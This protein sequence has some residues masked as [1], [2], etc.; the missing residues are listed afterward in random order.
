LAQTHPSTLVGPADVRIGVLLSI[1]AV[2]VLSIWN[3]ATL[4]EG[5]NLKYILYTLPPLIWAIFV[6]AL[7]GRINIERRSV[8]ALG[9]YLFV[10]AISVLNSDHVDW[11][12]LR[13]L[14]II[15]SY[16]AVFAL[17]FRSP[18]FVADA[19]LGFCLIA[20]VTVLLVRGI[21]SD[22]SITHPQGHQLLESV[23]SFPAGL[24]VLYYV[25]Q[26]QWGRGLITLVLFVLAFKRIAFVGVG[27]VLCLEICMYIFQR[28]RPVGRIATTA[29]VAM[30]SIVA[31]FSL[32][33]F[34]FL[35]ILLDE[36]DASANSV[37]LGR[38]DMAAE[39]WRQIYAADISQV[40]MGFGP[41]AADRHLFVAGFELNPHNDWLKIL[42]E[43]GIVGFVGLHVVLRLLLPNTS[44]GN[45][46]YLFTAIL[47]TTGNPL[48]Y[49]YY[50]VALFLIVRIPPQRASASPGSPDKAVVARIP[51]A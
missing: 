12:T 38:A 13:D 5:S 3:A 50:F 28:R 44:L 20:T 31:L 2:A 51:I 33:I 29:A 48:I 6:I 14:S 45:N 36:T 4:F 1:V 49:T 37:S 42:F 35:A 40:L 30:I 41:G 26:R 19:L 15:G 47:M 27:A 7:R 24:L 32:Q 34:E 11:Y 17:F 21:S 39:L 18:R 10:S 46:F 16:I 22:M 25:S 43:Y 8:Y 9:I 23:V